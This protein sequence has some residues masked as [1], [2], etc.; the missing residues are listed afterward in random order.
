MNP[1]N[2]L[3]PTAAAILLI[4]AGTFLVQDDRDRAI[5][6]EIVGAGEFDSFLLDVPRDE[7]YAHGI[8]PGDRL[9]LSFPDGA[10][11]AY[12]ICCHSGIASLDMYVNCYTDDQDVE[13]GIYDYEI[14]LL[15]DYGVGTKVS[16]SKEGGK[17]DYFDK[18]PHY[19]A[20][21]SEDRSDFSSEQEYG[22]YRE[23]T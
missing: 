2:L 6:A 11:Y 19:S 10:Y 5:E 1:A 18:I 14:G 9:V 22:N 7:F 16:I 12:F 23:V 8:E 21:Y 3:L 15:L 4:L 13:V 20:G 17:A